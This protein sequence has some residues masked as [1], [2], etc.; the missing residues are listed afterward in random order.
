M[1]QDEENVKERFNNKPRSSLRIMCARLTQANDVWRVWRLA[2]RRERRQ[3]Y[4]DHEIC[5]RQC[6]QRTNGGA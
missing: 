1:L 6:S 5:L 2:M 3:Q 4:V